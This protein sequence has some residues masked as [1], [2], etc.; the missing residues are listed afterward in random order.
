MQT[1]PHTGLYVFITLVRCQSSRPF[2]SA[3]M[4]FKN[5]VTHHLFLAARDNDQHYLSGFRAPGALVT[6][7]DCSIAPCLTSRR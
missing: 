2:T 7:V 5:L 3:E 4:Q 6:N 1:D